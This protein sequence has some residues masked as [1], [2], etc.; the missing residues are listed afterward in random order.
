MREML[1]NEI[2]P[3][4][5]MD[6]LNSILL[7]RRRWSALEGE[8]LEVVRRLLEFHYRS[9]TSGN[10]RMESSFIYYLPET[11]L[12]YTG[13]LY[14]TF[15]NLDVDERSLLDPSG[16]IEEIRRIAVEYIKDDMIGATLN[17]FDAALALSAL[18]L[19]R[20]PS[21]DDGVV[22]TAF[23]VLA[24]ARGE[25]R[26]GHP[27]KAYEWNRMRHPTRIIVGSEVATSLFVMNAAVDARRFLFGESIKNFGPSREKEEKK[28]PGECSAGRC[29]R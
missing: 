7:N 26:R 16:K 12:Y 1:G 23:K 3:G 17:V 4:H 21:R 5:N 29:E 18:V 28:A 10:F 15:L 20:Y 14:D 6:I 24:E 22:A 19:L 25:G 9:Y 27:Y 13:R 11:Y 2:C 8:N